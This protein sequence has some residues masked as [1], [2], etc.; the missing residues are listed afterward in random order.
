MSS[1]S[2]PTDTA[3][4]S[5]SSPPLRLRSQSPETVTAEP[6]TSDRPAV[7]TSSDLASA[8][9]N[10]DSVSPSDVPGDI[11]KKQDELENERK[12]RTAIPSES[13]PTPSLESPSS[14]VLTPSADSSAPT[15]V[16]APASVP[17]RLAPSPQPPTGPSTR[18]PSPALSNHSSASAQQ[19]TPATATTKKFSSINVNKRFLEK[20]VVPSVG[21]AG[22]SRDV[23]G[24]DPKASL[25]ASTTGS[26]SVTK[27]TAILNPVPRLLTT[28]LVHPIPTAPPPGPPPSSW[29]LKAT[30]SP[31][32]SS[33][34]PSALGGAQGE[35]SPVWRTSGAT[36]ADGGQSGGQP[37]S[38]G[39]APVG[40][41]SRGPNGPSWRVQDFPTTAESLEDGQKKQTD[42]LLA[43]QK[44]AAHQQAIL[45]ELDS[46][47][48]GHLNPKAQHWDELEDEN[49]DFLDEVVQF[50]DGFDFKTTPLPLP[51]APLPP[52]T[53]TT[54][55]GSSVN[56]PQ[57]PSSNEF[58]RSWP[59]KRSSISGSRGAGMS[60]GTGSSTHATHPS[61]PIPISRQSRSSMDSASYLS[62]SGGRPSSF[63]SSYPPRQI[64]PQTSSSSTSWKKSEDHMSSFSSGRMLFNERS[65]RLEASSS[66][67]NGNRPERHPIPPVPNLS[68][69]PSNTSI[70][71]SQKRRLSSDRLPPQQ[72]GSAFN[73]TGGWM[74]RGPPPHQEEIPKAGPP[75][76]NGPRGSSTDSSRSA[77][78]SAPTTST[79]DPV[80]RQPPPHLAQPRSI[81]S[82]PASSSYSH[83][84]PPLAGLPIVTEAS[85]D[86]RT[87][88][89]VSRAPDERGPLGVNRN[90][91]PPKTHPNPL[92]HAPNAYVLSSKPDRPE[93]ITVIQKGEM[94]SAAERARLRR[95]AEE[96]E[97]KAAAERAKAKAKELEKKLKLKAAEESASKQ[98]VKKSSSSPP[99]P[100]STT[101]P[102]ITPGPMALSTPLDNQPSFSSSDPDVEVIDFSDLAN[103]AAKDLPISPTDLVD[104][105]NSAST[106]TANN[107][108][109]RPSAS[110]FFDSAPKS[111]PAI[112]S[113]TH[114]LPS[115]ASSAPPVENVWR[116]SSASLKASFSAAN[117]QPSNVSPQPTVS[118]TPPLVESSPSL[119]V[120]NPD[121]LPPHPHAHPPVGHSSKNA[122]SSPTLSSHP[123]SFH[124]ELDVSSID[125][126]MLRLKGAMSKSQELTSPTSTVRADPKSGFSPTEEVPRRPS[127]SSSMASSAPPRKPSISSMF[128]L[129][130][131][132]PFTRHPRAPSPPPSEITVK[133]PSS[134]TIKRPPMNPSQTKFIDKP[135]LLRAVNTL[136][137]EPPLYI[138]LNPKTL[139]RDEMLLNPS[140]TGPRKFVARSFKV[141][142]SRKKEVSSE[143]ASPDVS[144]R[145]SNKA[146]SSSVDMKQAPSQTTEKPSAATPTPPVLAVIPPTPARPAWT[147]AGSRVMEETSWRRKDSGP[148]TVSEKVK[149]ES[150][151]ATKT[152][153][154]PKS[155]EK[156]NDKEKDEDEDEEKEKAE[157]K[158]EVSS[159]AKESEQSVAAETG[160][161]NDVQVSAANG[162]TTSPSGLSK[163]KSAAKMPEGTDVGFYQPRKN[164]VN[165]ASE[166]QLAPLV[167]FMVTSEIDD[168]RADELGLNSTDPGGEDLPEFPSIMRPSS[169]EPK[170]SQEEKASPSSRLLGTVLSSTLSPPSAETSSAWSKSPAASTKPSENHV[171]DLWAQPS[172]KDKIAESP[173]SSGL[174]FTPK[175]TLPGSNRSDVNSTG[176]TNNKSFTPSAQP[177]AYRPK[178]YPPSVETRLDNGE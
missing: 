82:P 35:A 19:S 30:P 27:P 40:E 172:G 101:Q 102:T 42:A 165:P 70:Q 45:Q 66:I 81:I 1:T 168:F 144:T 36:T 137:W 142:L 125:H 164:S 96:E 132:A 156:E 80:G 110:D 84:V 63:Q 171:K 100:D 4:K 92:D 109:K 123:K 140:P 166:E 9:D 32:P 141:S 139:S 74:D 149:P 112:R 167:R 43:K 160:T 20:V 116:R 131:E 28:K 25:N 169:S 34:R 88:L 94:H 119:A 173:F 17:S 13:P 7:K 174:Q 90:V 37:T 72:H 83:G 115:A 56:K 159:K 148:S 44:E 150:A 73:S 136:S 62:T 117:T 122:S 3:T 22:S 33:S 71:S 146:D 114:Q 126:A 170:L 85:A 65:N 128:K 145:Q 75:H 55:T 111:I 53:S 129:V 134:S 158:K 49:D 138:M 163:S 41:S 124:R 91:P 46:F 107:K 79:R 26:V 51:S 95:E 47:R 98:E 16:P 151:G 24:K 64:P 118:S 177:H 97:R 153:Q 10:S 127:A 15:T 161:T 154:T 105:T 31:V 147:S 29:G 6:E 77:W 14:D 104:S 58:D 121:S 54:S 157:V 18:N 23:V 93:N 59:Q 133:L 57:R 143:Q 176:F 68:T 5:T 86:P 120:K 87:S 48:G 106:S 11:V 162:R 2:P 60:I 38:G 21:F 50:E 155:E 89:P 103:M 135:D 12:Q 67:G 99:P 152:V 69:S 61:A 108:L 175:T 178:L 113:T 78:E 39:R 76:F 52:T 8:D 130:E